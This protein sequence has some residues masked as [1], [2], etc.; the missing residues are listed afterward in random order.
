MTHIINNPAYIH[1]SDTD[2]ELMRSYMK[3]RSNTTMDAIRD[4]ITEFEDKSDQ[5]MQQIAL[6]SGM[7][8]I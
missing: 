6:D 1:S 3:T 4:A 8:L 5:D 7:Q 2:I